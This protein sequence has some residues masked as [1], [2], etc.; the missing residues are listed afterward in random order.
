MSA[1]SKSTLEKIAL[2][3][4]IVT[5]IFTVAKAIILIPNDVQQLQADLAKVNA[6]R[7]S[8]HDLLQRID[9]RTA[10]TQRDIQELKGRK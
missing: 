4:A 9:E 8:D 3:M 2:G 7:S 1:E 5:F 6:A 10:Q